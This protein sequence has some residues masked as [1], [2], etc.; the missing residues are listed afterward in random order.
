MSFGPSDRDGHRERARRQRGLLNRRGSPCHAALMLSL[1]AGLL[2]LH[3]GLARAQYMPAALVSDAG[4]LEADDAYS[5]AMSADGRYV[6]F[7]GSFNDVHGV[8][9]KDLATGE[10]VLVAGEDAADPELSTPDAGSPSISE[11][12]RY[13]SFTTTARLD[14]TDDQSG[15]PGDCSSVYVR[16]MDIPAAE[17]GAYTLA[18]ALNGTTQGIAYA[19]SATVGC[20]GGGSAA[21]E[22]VALSGSGH[23]VAFTVLGESDL[24]TGPGG[25]RTTAPDQIAVRNLATDTTTLV[26][27][28]LS[29]VGSTPEAVPGGAALAPLR[30]RLQASDGR[31]I[32]GSTAAISADGS[33]VAWTGIDIAAQA[34]PF[35]AE[36]GGSV[37]YDEPL[38]RRIAEGPG[39][40]IRRVSGGDDPECGCAGPFDTAFDPNAGGGGLGPEYGTYVAP[41]GFGGDPLAGGL[42]LDSVT[43]QLSANGQTVAFLST[44]PLT[45]EVSRGLE[46]ELATSTANAY[47]VNMA[48]GLTRTAA[49]TPLTEWASNNFKDPASTGAVDGIAISPDGT[50]VAFTTARIEFPLSPPALVSPSLSQSGSAQLYVANLDAGTLQMVSNGYEGQ[51]ANGNVADPAFTGEGETLAFASSATNLVY[52]AYDKGAGGVPG[53]V[54]LT[55]E[56]NSPAVPGES[57]ISAPPPAAV[58]PQRWELLLDASSERNGMVELY[59]TVPGA[60]ALKAVAKAAVPV[61]VSAKGVKSAR[62]SAKRDQAS[63]HPAIGARRSEAVKHIALATRKVASASARPAHAGLVEL[64]LSLASVGK[65]LVQSRDGLYATITVTFTAHGASTLTGTLQATFKQ[66]ARKAAKKASKKR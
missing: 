34:S 43:P 61:S 53:N 16:D 4:S 26:S 21:A 29:S 47:V 50:K 60:G 36:G 40:P 13:V 65:A 41:G 15:E 8:Y 64:R 42:S 24:T 9:R 7:V 32:S 39:A 3:P 35:S 11:E 52:G 51:P 30:D 63:R 14:P 18:S 31:Q 59:A 20:P 10:L 17:P 27:Q 49:L 45:G 19:G 33:T 37:E 62:R 46:E 58:S 54:F 5:P 2:A 55:S 57:T 6:V 38:W 48:T 44:Q 12:G 66:V 56:V 28:T 25:A 1:A 22:R 23:E